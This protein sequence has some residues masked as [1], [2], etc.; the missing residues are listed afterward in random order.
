MPKSLGYGIAFTADKPH[1]TMQTVVP[2]G[3]E[4]SDGLRLPREYDVAKNHKDKY[5]K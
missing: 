1:K 3:V 5:M 2:K 4:E